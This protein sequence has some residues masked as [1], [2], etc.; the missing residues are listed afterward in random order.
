MLQNVYR[1]ARRFTRSIQVACDRLG[2]DP[3]VN[4]L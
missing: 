4:W 3:V 2:V 1:I